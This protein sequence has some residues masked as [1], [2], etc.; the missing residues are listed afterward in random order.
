MGKRYQIDRQK[1]IR[2]FGQMAEQQSAAVQL[3]LPLAEVVGML[4]EGVGN[5]L[6][7]AGLQLM[8]LIMEEEVRQVVGEKSRPDPER[9]ANR[10]GTEQGYCVVDGQKV[11]VRRPRVRDREKG[12]QALGSYELFRREGP[13]D[14]GVWKKMM[15]G[16]S[17]RNYGTVVKEFA[18]AYGVERSATSAH[19]V[20]AS[21]QKVKELMER[22]LGGLTLCAVVIDGTPLQG[23][24]FIVALGIGQEG[25]KTVLGFREGATE[26]ATVV[27]ELL[28]DLA[29]RGLDFRV[30]RL[31]VL[32]GS[33]A[34]VTAVRNSAGEA[35][36]IQRCQ[37]HKKRNV[38]EHLA[39]EERPA[40]GQKMS[41]AYA[42]VEEGEARESLQKLHR[43]L[44]HMNP[45]AARSLA[46]GL[47]ETLTVHRLHVPTTLRK[48]L[49][50]TNVIESM[51]S[52]VETAWRN[53]KR[54]R[55]GNHRERWLV[56]GVL[57]A[58]GKFRRV[59]GY[60]QI[61]QLMEAMVTLTSK[62]GVA[63]SAKVA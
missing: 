50:S 22:P 30:P 14:Q 24:H 18:Q 21:E 19:F 39:E 3:T 1:A 51:F 16:L 6:R 11:P 12:E 54:W 56:S 17:A 33:K 49:A 37:V 26:N 45:S 62:K 4:R 47:N 9:R 13:L 15:C 29:K 57:H 58:E 63:R 40:V 46:E 7:E 10:W 42:M 61:P 35:A 59:K 5:L 60:R 55:G 43:E 27:G 53:V 8:Q 23:S 31:Y 38:L 2:K 25:R 41:Q 32:D 36:L 20:R 34:L 28:E 48:T 52:V 44:M